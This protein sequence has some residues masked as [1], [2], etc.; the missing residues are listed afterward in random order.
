MRGRRE[1]SQEFGYNWNSV[2]SIDL[3]G[4]SRKYQTGSKMHGS[5]ITSKSKKEGWEAEFCNLQQMIKNSD[6][7]E[8]VH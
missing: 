8:W 4:S 5:E 3:K 7:N 1:K 2:I 6:S